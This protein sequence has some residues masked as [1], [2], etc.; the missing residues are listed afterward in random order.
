MVEDLSY[1]I[2]CIQ[3]AFD[4]LKADERF[5]GLL[6]LA[7]I[8]SALCFC[9]SA[10]LH[11]KN[12]SGQIGARLRT[13]FPLFAASVRYEGFLT[14]ERLAVHFKTLDSYKMGLASCWKT[15]HRFQS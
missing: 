4:L 6:T 5:L 7:R 10:A 11:S 1:D 12:A 2:A 14:V 8:V 15:N 9:L 3:Q 13:N